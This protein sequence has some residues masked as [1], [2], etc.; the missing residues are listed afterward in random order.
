MDDAVAVRV[1][2]GRGDGAADAHRVV[3][4]QLPLALESRAERFA[5]H[6]RHHVVQPSVGLAAVEQRHEVG[7]L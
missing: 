5:I 7:V 2:E 4:G 6:E 3:D 1:L